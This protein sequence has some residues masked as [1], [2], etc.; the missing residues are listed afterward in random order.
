MTTPPNL[1]RYAYSNAHPTAGAQLAALA[2]MLDPVSRQRLVGFGDLRGKRCLVVGA[3]GSGLPGWLADRVGPTGSVTATDI[4]VRHIPHHDRMTVVEH[5][6]TTGPPPG[7]PWDIIHARLVLMHLAA[8]E[9]VLALLADALTDRGVLL[10]EDWLLDPRRAVLAAHRAHDADVYSRYQ[11]AVIDILTTYGTDP[12]WATRIHTTMRG[13]GLSRVDT[14]IDAPVWTPGGPVM[15]LTEVTVA[16]HRDRLLA[17]GL[18]SDNLI[19][20][21]SLATALNSG[22][23]VRGHQLYSTAGRRRSPRDDASRM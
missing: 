14:R 22:L 18:T 20:V 10:I 1:P 6:I 8:R 11:H 3:G 15:V 19:T 16:K 13:I 2:A 21:E 12:D 17:A 23:V 9:V 7:G 5:D 4:D